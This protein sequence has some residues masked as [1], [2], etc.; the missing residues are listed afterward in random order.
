MGM[1]GAQSQ[2]GC[3]KLNGKSVIYSIKWVVGGELPSRL[4]IPES[5]TA[6]AAMVQVRGECF[7]HQGMHGEEKER[8]R[9]TH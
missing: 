8:Q 7:V 2:P 6:N 3:I 9:T 4:A 5:T 1:E